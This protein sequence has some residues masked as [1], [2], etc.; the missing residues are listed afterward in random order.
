MTRFATSPT[1]HFL[2]LVG[3]IIT[4]VKLSFITITLVELPIC[5][6]T[7][8]HFETTDFET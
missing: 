6:I 3:I 2:F 1:T 4:P 7:F 5:L 8:N